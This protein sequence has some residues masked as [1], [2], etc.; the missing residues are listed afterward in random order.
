MRVDSAVTGLDPGLAAWH[1]EIKR[2][3]FELGEALNYAPLTPDIEFVSFLRSMS[4]FG[5]FVVG[6]ITIDVNVVEDL[7]L[8]THPRGTGGPDHPPPTEEFFEYSRQCLRVAKNSGRRAFD[9]M[10]CLEVFMSWPTGLPRRV[11]G[12]LGLT[13]ADVT[14]F[15]SEMGAE[16]RTRPAEKLYSTDD[17]AA[18]LG[19]HVQTVR[20]WIRSGR[21]P[22]S[23]LA[24]QKSIRIRESD[25]QSV[26]EPIDPRQFD[27]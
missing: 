18:Y 8:R 2:I 23:R 5:F 14:R 24:G 20:S 25:L 15:Q 3:D 19:V 12:E 9:E 26:L 1:R 16:K 22:A 27:E 11:F 7:L 13:F 10:H 17:A 21:L 6:P 4:R